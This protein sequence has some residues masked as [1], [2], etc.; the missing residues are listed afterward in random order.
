MPPVFAG[1]EQPGDGGAAPRAADRHQ[2]PTEGQ[3]SGTPADLDPGMGLG[4]LG[5]VIVACPPS[6][7]AAS[8]LGAAL[9]SPFP[10]GLG[11]CRL[12]CLSQPVSLASPPLPPPDKEAVF[13]LRCG[14]LKLLVVPLRAALPIPACAAASLGRGKQTGGSPALERS[15]SWL[16]LASHF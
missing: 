5:G 4:M 7:C 3:G 8:A 16:Y 9:P 14:F 12:P 1:P 10:A 2:P 15:P 6:A 13:I 11:A